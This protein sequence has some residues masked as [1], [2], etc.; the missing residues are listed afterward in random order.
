M[1]A[2]QALRQIKDLK[3]KL[4]AHQEHAQGAVSYE[5]MKK[6]AF[7]FKSECEGV[8]KVRHELLRLQTMLAVSNATTEIEWKGKKVLIAWATRALEEIK[9]EKSWI[10]SLRVLEQD[11]TMQDNVQTRVVGGAYQ[12]IN[13]PKKFLCALPRAEQ[14]KRSQALQEEFNRLNDLVET[15]NHQTILKPIE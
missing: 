1:T 4:A 10:D 12:Q 3:G 11:V 14:F 6:P 8:E 2:S 13:E 9:G 7:D 5:D 15:S